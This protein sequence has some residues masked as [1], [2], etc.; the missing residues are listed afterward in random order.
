M[1][2]M[3]FSFLDSSLTALLSITDIQ[4]FAY[5]EC[6]QFDGFEHMQTPVIASPQLR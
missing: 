6:M 5:I 3:S 4:N 1:D 2:Q